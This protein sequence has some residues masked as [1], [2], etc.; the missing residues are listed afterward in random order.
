MAIERSETPQT[1]IR[2][3]IASGNYPDADAAVEDAILTLSIEAKSQE[4]ERLLQIGIDQ[5]NRGE[6]VPLTEEL[7]V[8]MRHEAGRRFDA[9][10]RCGYLMPGCGGTDVLHR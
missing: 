5:A 4:L 3:L 9:G 7:G 10:A 1:P 8:L 2:E 6:T